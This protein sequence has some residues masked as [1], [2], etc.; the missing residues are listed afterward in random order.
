MSNGLVLSVFPGI[1]LLGRAFEEEGYCVVRG[2][3]LLWGGDI[4]TFHPPVGVFEGV[5]G[6][7]PC[8]AFAQSHNLAGDKAKHGNLIPEFER[9]VCGALPG[10]FLMENVTAA[11]LPRPVGYRVDHCTI[12]AREHG[13]KQLRRR[14]FSWGVDAWAVGMALLPPLAWPR[15]EPGPYHHTFTASPVAQRRRDG[16]RANKGRAFTWEEYLDAFGLPAGF[17]LPPFRK[18]AKFAALGNAVPMAMG[19]AIAKAVRRAT[20]GGSE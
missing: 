5:I 10:W 20:S 4:R 11:P 13:A 18:D 1:D 12:E 3:D 19:R 8:Q 16:T 9:V 2:P 14:R 7:P 6:G 15:G 17:D